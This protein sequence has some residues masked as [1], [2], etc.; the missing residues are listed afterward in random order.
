MSGQT[1]SDDRIKAAISVSK[2]CSLMG[3]SRSQ[4]Y[5]HVRKGTFHAPLKLPNGRPYYN[6][7]QVDDNLKAREMGVGVNG[8]Y[9]IFYERGEPCCLGPSKPVPKPKADFTDLIDGLS[10]L[11]LTNVTTAI[12]EKAVTDCYPKGTTAHDENDILRTVFRHLK[13]AGTG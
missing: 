13:R 7:S 2:M 8:Q 6:A 5:A 11:G 10:S 3:M 12:V 4:F 9:V 1:M